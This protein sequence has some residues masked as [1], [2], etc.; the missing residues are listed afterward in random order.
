MQLRHASAEDFPDILAI[1]QA[2][3]HFTSPMDLVKLQDMDRESAYHK[4]IEVDD[5]IA[6]FLLVMHEHSNYHSVNFRWFSQRLPRFFYIDR[7]VIAEA[8]QGQGMGKTLYL[9]LFDVARQ[10]Q[11]QHITCEYNTKPSN[12]ASQAFHASLGFEEIG[13]QALGPEKAV[14]MQL[15]TL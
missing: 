2:Y 11:V 6:A 4:V 14:S 3:V 13:S 15:L 8:F 5:E 10:Q 7:I 12:P 1:N 9:D